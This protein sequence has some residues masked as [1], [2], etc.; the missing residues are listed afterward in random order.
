[1]GERTSGENLD[2]K[3]AWFWEVWEFVGLAH[4]LCAQNTSGIMIP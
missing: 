3:R 2:G 4:P 1:M